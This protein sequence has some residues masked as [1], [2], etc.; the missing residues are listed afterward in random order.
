MQEEPFSTCQSVIVYCLRREQTE[1][2]ASLLR[3]VFQVSAIV[4][5]NKDCQMG[6]IG[7]VEVN[8][9]A[10]LVPRE[11]FCLCVSPGSS[12]VS[13]FTSTVPIHPV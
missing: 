13:Q 7:T 9:D 11:T 2:I 10:G 3:T 4:F 12:P 6:W 8:R 1:Q 5:S